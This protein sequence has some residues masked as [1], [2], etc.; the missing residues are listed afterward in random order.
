M[1]SLRPNPRPFRF[2]VQGRSL[3]PRDAWLEMVRRAEATG[4]STYLALDHF[5]RGLD[6]VASLMAAAMSTT[7]LRVGGFVFDNDFRHPA[8]LAKAAT[9]IDV[10]SGGR[11]ELGLG[12]GW[13]KEEYDQTGIPFDP[14][15]IR[16]ARMEEAI[17]LLKLI[18]TQEHPVSF[19]GAH[20][21]VTDLIC[22]PHPV[23]RPHPPFLIGGGSR[24]ILSVAAR[25]AEIVGITTRARHDGLKETTDLT[26]EATARKLEWVRAAA[27]ERFAGIELNMVVGDVVATGDRRAAAERLAGEHGV[28]PEEILDSPLVLIGRP[29]EMIEHLLAQRERFGFSYVV[30]TEPNLDRLAP[31]VARLAGT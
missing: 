4:F 21:T 14:A 31:V 15:G 19:A 30:V 5:V 28:T 7:T 3:G 9:T 23:Q 25:E 13:L 1:P 17:R 2:G 8:L 26:A 20:Y 10:L 6:P 22:P 16:I 29:E 18:F 27:G 12:A 11:F 24:R